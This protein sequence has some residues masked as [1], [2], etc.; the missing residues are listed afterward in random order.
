MSFAFWMILVA[1]ML[2]Y[3]TTALAKSGGGYDNRSPRDWVGTLE[4]WR[5][6]A[7]AAHRNHFEA[8]P[9]FAAAVLVATLAHAPQGRVDLLA[10]AFVALRVVYTGMYVADW[11]AMRSLIWAAGLLCILGLFVAGV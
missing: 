4:G 6:R 10:G 3:V 2:P 1:A 5:R 8:F 7:D 9:I 11:A